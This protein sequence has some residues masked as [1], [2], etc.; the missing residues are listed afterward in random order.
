MKKLINLVLILAFC[1]SLLP[2]TVVFGATEVVSGICGDDLAWIFENSTLTISGTGNMYDYAT[3]TSP[4][5]SLRNSIKKIIINNGVKTIGNCAFE[6]CSN[7]SVVNIESDLSSIGDFAFRECINLIKFDFM[8]SIWWIGEGAFLN[9]S[10]LKS[11]R[12]SSNVYIEPYAFECCEKLEKI[13]IPNGIDYIDDYAFRECFGL[14]T[15]DVYG[16]LENFSGIGQICSNAF[17]DCLSLERVEIPRGIS[18]I[19]S[20]VFRGCES[21]TQV[22]IP[23]SV[24]EIDSTVF[25]GCDNLTDVYYGGNEERWEM[26]IVDSDE[27]LNATIHFMGGDY[28]AEILVFEGTSDGL[29]ANIIIDNNTADNTNPFMVFAVYDKDKSLKFATI[30]ERTIYDYSTEYINIVTDECDYEEGDYARVFMWEDIENGI[31]LVR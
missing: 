1:I 3:D 9:C 21:L 12:M 20:Q 19:D 8:D 11:I 6:D 13:T 30:I 26:L 25:S 4:W 29:K 2:N 17:L 10:S 22:S 28:G 18:I 7:L 16:G 31:P 23:S 14:K 24:E 15:V 5:Y 27:L